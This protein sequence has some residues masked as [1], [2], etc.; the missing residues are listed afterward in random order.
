VKQDNLITQKTEVDWQTTLRKPTT[1]GSNHHGNGIKPTKSINAG[2]V[3]LDL[4]HNSFTDA[5]SEELC[6][7][8]YKK[9][10]LRGKHLSGYA[11]ALQWNLNYLACGTI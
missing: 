3:G 10:P 1:V 11:I 2:L 5:L 6:P 4:S 7:L 8:L 9:P